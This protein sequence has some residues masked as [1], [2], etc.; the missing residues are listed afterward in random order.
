MIT[1]APQQRQS[2]EEWQEGVRWENRF[3]KM[4]D[5]IEELKQ[6][7]WWFYILFG[8]VG[9]LAIGLFVKR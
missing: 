5:D 8:A 6:R 4:E 7:V 1:L 9:L 3:K 2:S